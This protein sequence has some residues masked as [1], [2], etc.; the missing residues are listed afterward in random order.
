MLIKYFTCWDINWRP[1]VPILPSALRA[2]YLSQRKGLANNPFCGTPALPYFF[3]SSIIFLAP[4]CRPRT[5]SWFYVC[6]LLLVWHSLDVFWMVR[7]I[8]SNF[9]FFVNI[10]PKPQNISRKQEQLSLNKGNMKKRKFGWMVIGRSHSISN[11]QNFF[12]VQHWLPIEIIFGEI[13]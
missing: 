8:V 10:H 11:N 1:I 9:K 12:L 6:M 13:I 7:K 3:Q 5:N 4:N 2:S